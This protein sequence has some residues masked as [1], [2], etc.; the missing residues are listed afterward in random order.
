[1]AGVAS[2]TNRERRASRYR[3]P[4]KLG[5]F[6]TANKI[7]TYN[8]AVVAHENGVPFYV[9]AP[10]TTIDLD[11]PTGDAIEIEERTPDEVHFVGETRITPAG[12]DVGNPAF[13]V[14][15]ARYITAIITERGV[16]Y[17]PY[18]EN[19]RKIMRQDR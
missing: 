18:E 15:P 16:V 2:F 19:L 3:T 5:L 14:T 12:V 10:T 13:D 1:M 17:P 6:S 8:L 7:G 11:T 4:L 9:A